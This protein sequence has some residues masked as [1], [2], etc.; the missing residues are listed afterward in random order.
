MTPS[1]TDYGYNSRL[2]DPRYDRA[3]YEDVPAKRLLAWFVDIAVIA[4]LVGFL[5][6]MSA[7]TA[8][9]FLPLVVASV[10]F[11]YRWMTLAG[12]SATWGMRVMSIELRDAEG[13]KFDSSTAFKHTLGYTLSVMTFPLQLVSIT[14]MALGARGQGVTDT[15][16]GTVAVNRTVT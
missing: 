8:L 4:F 3:I 5:V 1:M 15:V 16:L 13:E 2:P 12:G 7:L 9:L 11:L 14:M 6:I 10:S